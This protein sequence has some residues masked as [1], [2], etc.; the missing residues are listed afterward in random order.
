M[1]QSEFKKVLFELAFYVMVCDGEL[2]EKELEEIKSIADDSIYFDGLNHE[3]ELSALINNFKSEGINSVVEFYKR[4]EVTEF[5][6]TEEKH[7]IEVLIRIVEADERVDDNEIKF[8]S[9]IRKQL[10]ISDT[11]IIMNFPKHIDL[12]IPAIDVDDN[13]GDMNFDSLDFEELNDLFS[14]N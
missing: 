6:S 14:D 4:L 12:L 8:I 3:Q 13:L 9:K 1:V 2:H 10:N 11:E 5:E 7:L